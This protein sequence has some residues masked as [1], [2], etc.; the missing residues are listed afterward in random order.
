MK[1]EAAVRERPSLA[2]KGIACAMKESK[3]SGRVRKVARGLLSVRE[4]LERVLSRA[5]LICAVSFASREARVEARVSSEMPSVVMERTRGWRG[6]LLVV[7]GWWLDDGE[8]L[9]FRKEELGR[10]GDGDE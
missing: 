6:E 1:F 3:V 10:D 8:E 9:G 4:R 5:A 2:V 7:S